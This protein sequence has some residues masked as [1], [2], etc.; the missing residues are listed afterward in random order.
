MTDGMNGADVPF[1]VQPAECESG[2]VWVNEKAG[3]GGGSLNLLTRRAAAPRLSL[4]TADAL[5]CRF[6]L[7]TP[8]CVCWTVSSPCLLH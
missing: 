6:I 2:W 8:V 7:H 3:S 5:V 4:Q 1:R